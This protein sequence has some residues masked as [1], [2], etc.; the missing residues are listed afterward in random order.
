MNNASNVA[1][2]LL[3]FGT[4]L[5][6]TPATAEAPRD[7]AFKALSPGNQKV[8]R[9]LHDA[10]IPTPVPAPSTR[11]GSRATPRTMT[12]DEIA[13]KRQACGDWTCVLR[14]MRA[15]KL[16]HEKTVNEILARQPA[17]TPLAGPAP[18]LVDSPAAS[19]RTTRP[20]SSL[21]GGTPAR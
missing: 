18:A 11:S 14:S 15:R 17:P 4:V 2:T 7:G 9:A 12:L 8:A 20:A 16:V 13:A 21:S 5:G 6:S 3:L 19:P 10:Q 1:A